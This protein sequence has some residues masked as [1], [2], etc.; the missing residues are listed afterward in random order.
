MPSECLV[1][2]VDRPCAEIPGGVVSHC[3]SNLLCRWSAW[4]SVLG[5][6]ATHK[7][8]SVSAAGIEHENAFR[9]G[10][11]PLG[12]VQ[13]R[14]LLR[15]DRPSSNKLVFE[16]PLLG[17][18]GSRKKRYSRKRHGRN[19]KCGASVHNFPSCIPCRFHD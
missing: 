8:V 13:G 9:I 1:R 2:F 14:E 18:G 6:I 19:G 7:N 4:G 10:D 17:H 16:R 11:L 12:A 15:D 5:T 3:G